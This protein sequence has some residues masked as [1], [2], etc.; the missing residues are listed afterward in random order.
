MRE[1][2]GDDP[3]YMRA[4]A[5]NPSLMPTKLLSSVNR[6]H[7]LIWAVRGHD[8]MGVARGLQVPDMVADRVNS[9]T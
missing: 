5:V 2:A 7:P 6:R 4:G 9:P 1:K 3:D 8:G